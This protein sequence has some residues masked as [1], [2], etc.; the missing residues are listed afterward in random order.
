MGITP[1]KSFIALWAWQIKPN[2]P[3]V[4]V[5]IVVNQSICV[6]FNIALNS[7]A[8]QCVRE[9]VN[10]RGCWCFPCRAVVQPKSQTQL[11]S[12]PLSRPAKTYYNHI[13]NF[14][15]FY[16]QLNKRVD[17]ISVGWR[18]SACLPSLSTQPTSSSGSALS[19]STDLLFQFPPPWW[20]WPRQRQ[21]GGWWNI[22]LSECAEERSHN[23]YNIFRS[24]FV[25]RAYDTITLSWEQ[26]STVVG[27]GSSSEMKPAKC[28]I[29]ISNHK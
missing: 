16:G 14:H 6:N 12:P 2:P 22:R 19:P 27:V 5:T 8:L 20:H 26:Q 17:R 4:L 7:A 13:P 29:P 18:V 3:V 21:H 11:A 15:S 23:N 25:R 10:L 1:S 24:H 9:S 28:P